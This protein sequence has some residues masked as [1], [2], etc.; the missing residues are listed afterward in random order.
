MF[1][2][3]FM[4]A[5]EL[6][7]QVSATGD[8]DP[9][10]AALVRKAFRQL[11]LRKTELI[12]NLLRAGADPIITDADA[13]ITRDPTPFVVSLLPEAQILVTSDHQMDTAHLKPDDELHLESP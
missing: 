3:A 2:G 9:V 1:D 13:L 11:G 8:L 6:A 4:E 5:E 7:Q 12:L 10:Q